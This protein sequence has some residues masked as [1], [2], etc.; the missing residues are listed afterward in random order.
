MR[1]VVNKI[2]LLIG[3]L[4][5]VGAASVFVMWQWRIDNSKEQIESY[6]QTIQTAIPE[7]QG[8]VL[9]ESSDNIMP[10]LSIEGTDFIGLL[11][12][13]LYESV[14]PVCSE[15]GSITRYPCC[16]SGSIYDGSMQ[17]GATSQKGQYDYYR[18][19][20]VGD[21]VYFTD[22]TGNRFGYEIRDL[23]YVKHADKEVL[24]NEDT[25]LIL[26][27]KN[28]YGFEYLVIYCDSL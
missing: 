27:V 19:I 24:E 18:E 2:Y 28:L 16:F 17:I 3:I 7:P 9:E 5:M 12:L 15:W 14:L 10:M 20:S 25:E 21:Q 11:E 4:F 26:F 23:Q 13:P 8:A 6:V 1:S 22:M